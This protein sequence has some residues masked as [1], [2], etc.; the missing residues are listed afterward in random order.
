MLI[1]LLSYPHIDQ[2]EY[3][4]QDSYVKKK[5]KRFP[6]LP[7]YRLNLEFNSYTTYVIIAS[8]VI[9]TTKL[10]Y[11]TYILYFSPFVVAEETRQLSH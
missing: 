8:G 6:N 10:K 9:Y 2:R 5:R 7:M 3:L 11:L 4:L 1:L